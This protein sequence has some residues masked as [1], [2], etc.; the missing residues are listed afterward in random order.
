MPTLDWMTHLLQRYRMLCTIMRIPPRLRKPRAQTTVGSD[1]TFI[2]SDAGVD[3]RSLSRYTRKPRLF[4]AE[5]RQ[6]W[7]DPYISQHVLDTHLDQSTDAGSR[8]LETIDSSCE[9]ISTVY[10]RTGNRARSNAADAEH[11]PRLLD[12]GCG[13]GLYALRFQRSGFHVTGFDISPA[14]VRY[15]TA[16]CRLSQGSAEFRQEDYT[17]SELPGSYDVATCIY[18]GMGTISDS[19]RDK[20][21]RR[22]YRALKPGGLFFFD[23]FTRAYVDTERLREGWHIVS[24]DGF[25]SPGRYLVLESSHLFPRAAACADSY[26]LLFGDGRADRYLVWHRYYDSDEIRSLTR[27]AGFD[28]VETYTDLC[29]TPQYAGSFWIGVVAH[30]PL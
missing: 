23:V 9:W 16:H 21:T 3:L 11:A 4:E 20:L 8:R 26:T 5:R 19:K 17:D 6:F 10:D 24:R 18:G 22:V 7:A 29:G 2:A 13:P 14:A 25:W 27:K 12:L 1:G 15:A 28:T 30:K